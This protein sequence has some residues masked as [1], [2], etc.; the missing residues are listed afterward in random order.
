MQT[1]LQ[2]IIDEARPRRAMFTTF[3]FSANWF[4]S[5]CLPLL[6]VSGCHKVDLLVDSREACKST[7]ET[8]SLHAGIYYRVIP[9][10]QASGGFFHPKIAYLERGSG[11]DV[12]VVGSG[13]LTTRGQNS[14]LEVLDSVNALEHPFVFETFGQ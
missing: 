10:R 7:D 8:S 1:R 14:N 13:N 5:F 9:V 11:D 12:L 2:A 6:R 4:E 3:T